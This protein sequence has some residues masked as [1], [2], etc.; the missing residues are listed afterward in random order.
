MTERP[1][2][3]TKLGT[4]GE[5]V[6]RETGVRIERTEKGWYR[7]LRPADVTTGYIGIS[8]ARRTLADARAVAAKYIRNVERPALAEAYAEAVAEDEARTLT[9]L[10]ANVAA[11]QSEALAE[12][13]GEAHAEALAIEAERDESADDEAPAECPICGGPIASDGVCADDECG[14]DEETTSVASARAERPITFPRIREGYYHNVETGVHAF[15]VEGGY[16]PCTTNRYGTSVPITDG[17]CSTLKQ[18]RGIMAWSAE[19]IREASGAAF[20][21]AVAEDWCRYGI[22]AGDFVVFTDPEV[23][24]INTDMVWLVEQVWGQGTINANADLVE[25][26]HGQMRSAAYFDRLAHAPRCGAAPW[27]DAHE[28]FAKGSSNLTTCGKLR[29]HPVHNT[30][31]ARA[32]ATIHAARDH[33][34]VSTG[35]SHEWP[36]TTVIE[37]KTTAH[38]P[39]ALVDLQLVAYVN[40][41]AAEQGHA[42]VGG[43]RRC[44]QS[45]KDHGKQLYCPLGPGRFAAALAVPADVADAA[46]WAEYVAALPEPT[47]AELAATA[48]EFDPTFAAARASAVDGFRNAARTLWYLRAH[49]KAPAGS[50]EH[51]ALRQSMATFRRVL[52]QYDEIAAAQTLPIWQE[53]TL[54]AGTHF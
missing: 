41:W 9:E 10:S 17:P 32:A 8:L 31:R 36:G 50:A 15:R 40:A 54:A 12:E 28:F 33:E 26:P 16:L 27:A 4:L 22:E 39:K 53:E 34:G 51:I 37:P 52:R 1:I 20:V 42:P 13:I 3:F 30:D 35:R 11:V 29:P 48:A 45:E 18:A 23:I 14:A 6:N 49:G 43:C 7:P 2:T 25:Y 44:G 5:W 24:G 47:E 46:G 21:E 38:L 19:R